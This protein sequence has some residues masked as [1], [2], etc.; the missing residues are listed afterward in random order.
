MLVAGSDEIGCPEFPIASCPVEAFTV[1]T[2][3]PVN[4]LT[5]RNALFGATVIAIGAAPSV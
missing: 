4:V 1:Y 3:I 2:K 5:Y